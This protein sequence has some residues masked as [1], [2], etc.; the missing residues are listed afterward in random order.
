M[1]RRSLLHATAALIG[2]TLVAPFAA[3]A[4]SKPLLE[5]WKTASCGCCHDWI[6]H[7]QANGFEVKTHDISEAAKD[8]LRNQLGLIIFQRRVWEPC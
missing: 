5:V 4:A 6:K 1:Q 7:I 8:K 3:F 2:T